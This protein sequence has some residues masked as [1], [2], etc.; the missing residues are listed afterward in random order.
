MQRRAKKCWLLLGSPLKVACS[1][2]GSLFPELPDTAGSTEARRCNSGWWNSRRRQGQAG[3]AQLRSWSHAP[4]QTPLSSRSHG[5]LASFTWATEAR[6]WRR[7]TEEGRSKGKHSEAEDKLEWHDYLTWKWPEAEARTSYLQQCH[8][9]LLGKHG[10][11]EPPKSRAQIS[12]CPGFQDPS[13]GGSFVTSGNFGPR[14]PA[15][16][17]PSW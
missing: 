17:P 1:W 16:A 2:R 11:K 10:T 15:L 5:R 6:T 4:A 14:G 7:K 9:S 8:C 3:L 12:L 13:G